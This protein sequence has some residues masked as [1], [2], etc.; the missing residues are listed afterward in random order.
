MLKSRATLVGIPVV[1]LWIIFNAKKDKRVRNIVLLLT[2]VVFVFFI[3]HPSAYESLIDNVIFAG[4]DS[5]NIDSI[6]SGRAN[7]WRNFGKDFS[8]AWLFGYGDAKRE[9]VI[10][11]ALLE[12]GVLGGSLVLILAIWPVAWGVRRLNKE[13]QFYMLF[14]STALVYFTNGIFEQLTPFGPGVKCYFLWFL[15]G[16]LLNREF[17]TWGESQL[18]KV[19]QA[20]CL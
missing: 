8:E 15:F 1:L 9:S 20:R 17:N 3:F 4:R 6:S 18:M 5:G 10:L 11:T 2:V 14:T 7:E 12:F 13:S 19:G 16:V